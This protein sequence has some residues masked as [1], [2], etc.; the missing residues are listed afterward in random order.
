VTGADGQL[1]RCIRELAEDK[2]SER[3]V[4][5]DT[6][7]LDITDLNKVLQYFSKYQPD[8]CINCA[9]YTQVD[10]AEVEKDKCNLINFHGVENLIRASYEN[11]TVFIQIS[12]DFVFDGKKRKPYKTDDQPNPLNEYGR[13]KYLSEKIIQSSLERYFIVRTSWLYS[14]YGHNFVKTMLR[15]GSERDEIRVVKDQSGSP[16]YARDLAGF[17]IKLIASGNKAYGIYH[18]SNRGETNWY[19]FA[20]EI[21][22][23][24]HPNALVSP[25]N[26]GELNLAAVRPAFSVMD[27]EKTEAIFPTGIPHWKQSLGSC[28]KRLLESEL[29][30]E[31][32]S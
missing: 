29:S 32:K 5:T 16:T 8:Y 28:L 31:E 3:F 30:K 18:Y 22:S 14:E 6:N 2:S 26:S 21:L 7:E 27:L 9:A 25:I 15:L 24:S 23:S 10:K 12:T 4:F 13:S 11:Q 20:R 17:L 19:E 1:G